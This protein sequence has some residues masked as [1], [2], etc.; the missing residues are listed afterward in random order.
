MPIPTTNIARVASM[1]GAP[2][3]APIPISPADCGSL[4][5]K[6]APRIA[7]IGIMVSGRAVPTAAST[8]PTL[9]WLSPSRSPRISTALVNR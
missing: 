2:S 7:T 4:P 6:T 5:A 8:L 9:P 1:N 3:M